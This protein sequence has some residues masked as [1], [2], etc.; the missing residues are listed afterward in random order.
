MAKNRILK[1]GDILIDEYNDEI[2]I[3]LRQYRLLDALKVWDIHW[4]KRNL[5]TNDQKIHHYEEQGLHILIKEGTLKHYPG[6]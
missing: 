5:H 3:L 1:V 6:N 4:T 2:G